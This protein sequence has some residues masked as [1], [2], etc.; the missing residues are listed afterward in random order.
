MPHYQSLLGGKAFATEV[1]RWMAFR[2]KKN[3]SEVTWNTLNLSEE[4]DMVHVPLFPTTICSPERIQN[5][6]KGP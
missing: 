1:P 2:Q 4:L 5:T 6:E 3:T